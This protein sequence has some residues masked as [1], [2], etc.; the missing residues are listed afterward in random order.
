MIPTPRKRGQIIDDIKL[1]AK[2]KNSKDVESSPAQYVAAKF[3]ESYLYPEDM[4][5]ILHHILKDDD[6]DY[7]IVTP[8]EYEAIATL[9][10]WLGT[11]VGFMFLESLYKK[12]KEQV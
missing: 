7:H 10:Q 5:N 1:L 4:M 9:I 12:V 2:G 8:D 6:E 3:W 11:P